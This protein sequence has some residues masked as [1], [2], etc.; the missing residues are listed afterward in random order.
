MLEDDPNS[1]AKVGIRKIWLNNHGVLA[2]LEVFADPLIWSSSDGVP[3]IAQ[4]GQATGLS[5][6]TATITA[7]A[8]THTCATT[9]TCATLTVGDMTPPVLT[10]PRLS[11]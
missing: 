6:G 3:N 4:I 2:K 7:T 9:G 10:L 11:E 1:R 8:G 5:R